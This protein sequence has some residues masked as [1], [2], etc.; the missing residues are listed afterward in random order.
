LAIDQA[1]RSLN[2]WRLSNCA[3]VVTLE[4]CTMCIGA[5]RLARIAS[6]IY[7]AEEPKTGACGSI[8]DL[9]INDSWGAPTPRVIRGVMREEC[10]TLL[11]DFF[12]KLR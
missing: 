10:Q 2:S 5:I 9:S 7:G 12:Q 1:A 11:S 6:I 3:L 8:Y 4:P